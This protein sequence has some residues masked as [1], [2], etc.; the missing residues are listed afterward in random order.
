MITQLTTLTYRP[1]LYEQSAAKFW[2]DEHISN[3]MLKS[4]LDPVNDGATNNHAF[5]RES[6]RWISEIA[7]AEKYRALLDLGCG[8]GVYAELFDKAGYRVTGM[9]Y[10]ERSIHYA[11]ASAQANNAQVTYKR[12]NYLTLNDRTQFNMVTMINYDFGALSTDNR[13]ALLKNVHAALIKNGLF[14]FDV[15]TPQKFSDLN[16]NRSWECS[17]GGFWSPEP[18]LS[19][20]SV[21]RYD[22]QNTILRQHIVMTEHGVNCYNLW[23]HA[24]I[25]SELIRDLKNA[26][27]IVKG[28]YG[29]IA[30][31]KYDGEGKEMCVVAQKE[32][33]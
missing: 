3:E 6:V 17:S 22:E 29:N 2:D 13:A 27:F 31:R 7:P 28:L 25:E 24:F 15:F 9:D 19:L 10:S 12:C 21:Y 20:N 33:H 11:R 23:D 18:Y 5:V 26:G 16:E 14:I 8:P 32:A 1:D 30:G 4:H